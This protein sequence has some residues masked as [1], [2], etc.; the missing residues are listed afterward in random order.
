MIS[1]AQ[2]I[3]YDFILCRFPTAFTAYSVVCHFANGTAGIIQFWKPQGPFFA[4]NWGS[5]TSSAAR[6]SFPRVFVHGIG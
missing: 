3:P 2:Q 5:L 6:L 4:A 1:Q